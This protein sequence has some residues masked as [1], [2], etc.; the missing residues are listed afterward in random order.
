MASVTDNGRVWIGAGARWTQFFG[1]SNVYLESALLPGVDIGGDGP[2]LG[3]NLQFRSSLGVG[4]AFDNGATLLAAY[5]HRSNAD[6][7]AINPGLETIS[8]RYA[9]T[10]D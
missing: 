4:Y 6:T 5:D 3:G 9:I 2:D 8:I 7:R 10:W 1:D